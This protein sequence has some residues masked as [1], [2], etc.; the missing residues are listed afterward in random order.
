MDW[1]VSVDLLKDNDVITHYL[2][3]VNKHRRQLAHLF[4]TQTA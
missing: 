1:V 4:S 2:V 3:N